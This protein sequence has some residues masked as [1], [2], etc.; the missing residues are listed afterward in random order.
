[1]EQQRLSVLPRLLASTPK[2]TH[3]WLPSVALSLC[4]MICVVDVA[5][6]QAM[7]DAMPV[8]CKFGKQFPPANETIAA[9]GGGKNVWQ[10][11][12]TRDGKLM[13]RLW[14]TW[15]Q[16]SQ[17][18]GGIFCSKCRRFTLLLRNRANVMKSWLSWLFACFFFVKFV[19]KTSVVRVLAQF[20]WIAV[21]SSG[22]VFGYKAYNVSQLMSRPQ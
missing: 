6:G 16:K 21:K 1:M 3:K 2:H 9:M 5:Q 19:E 11:K 14:G 12:P 4:A 7:P 18:H 13:L 17:F 10:L 20:D 15:R 22:R 8:T